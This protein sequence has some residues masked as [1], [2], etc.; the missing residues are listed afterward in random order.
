MAMGYSLMYQWQ[1][2]GANIVNS[3]SANYN[4][5]NVIESDEGMYQCIVSNDVGMV[6]VAAQLTVCK[7]VQYEYFLVCKS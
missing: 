5:Q 4:I 2:D 6:T 3:I 7:F 1:K